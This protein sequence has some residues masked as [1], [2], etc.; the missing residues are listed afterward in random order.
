M[1]G[2]GP[3]FRELITKAEK[4][5]REREIERTHRQIWEI[6]SVVR[7]KHL[8]ES[9]K[10]GGTI[11]DK[12]VKSAARSEKRPPETPREIAQ[13]VGHLLLSQRI[14]VWFPTLTWWLTTFC[15]SVPGDP[16]LSSDFYGHQRNTQTSRQNSHIP[17]VN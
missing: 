11:S 8:F 3:A 10:S 9:Q 15:D 1:V 5:K 6:N 4:K 17:N 12:T 13:W 2:H 14:W 7:L 16:V